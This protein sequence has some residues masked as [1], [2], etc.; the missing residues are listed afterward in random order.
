MKIIFAVVAVA[1][2]MV[3]P[4]QARAQSAAAPTPVRA[5]KA[6]AKPGKALQ[7]HPIVWHPTAAQRG[8]RPADLVAVTT[9]SGQKAY[10]RKRPATQRPAT[11]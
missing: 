10:V 3:V 8:L 4:I 7:K 11:K 1:V 5:T 2:A 9:P 6:L